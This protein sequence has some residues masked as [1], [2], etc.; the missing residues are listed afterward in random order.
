MKPL[1]CTSISFGETKI[2]FNTVNVKNKWL[3]CIMDAM[4][5]FR[6]YLN[7]YFKASL[8]AK[9]MLWISVFIHPEIRTNS[10]DK[11]FA[12]W[13]ALK[14]RLGGT[15]KWSYRKLLSAGERSLT[16]AILSRLATPRVPPL[17]DKHTLTMNQLSKSNT[18]KKE[19]KKRPESSD[20]EAFSCAFPASLVLYAGKC[21]A[22]AVYGKISTRH[23]TWTF[24]ASFLPRVSVSLQSW[25]SWPPTPTSENLTF[26]PISTA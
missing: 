10:H 20:V 22:H 12:L 24:C 21:I 7:F 15:R 6:V 11:N 19:K 9:Y 8:R 4:R 16:L 26:L 23:T 3:A 5:H 18:L 13:L 17:L 25:M 1:K 2:G 14:E